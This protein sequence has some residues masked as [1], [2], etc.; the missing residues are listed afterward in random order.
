MVRGVRVAYRVS[1]RALL[2]SWVVIA[3]CGITDFTITQPVPE[4]R[5]DGSGIPDLPISGLFE[6]PL[7]LDLQ[8]QIEKQATG[9]I[10]SITL[11][12][13]TLSITPAD[14]PSGDWSFVDEIHVFVRSSQ[15]G[16]ALPRVEIASVVAPGP[17]VRMEFEVDESID[18]KPYVDEGSL[19]E[20]EAQGTVPADDVTY[21]GE[22][23]FTVHPL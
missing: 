7:D 14:Q 15:D 12:S 18:L 8:A 10:D 11:A 17:V 22:G 4:Q 19:V 6:I 23:V 20:S 9:P 5:V 16:S 1:V 2:C 3:G 21:D 13:L